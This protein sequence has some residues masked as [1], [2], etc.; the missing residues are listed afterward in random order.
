MFH[1][2]KLYFRLTFPR[3]SEEIAAGIKRDPE[4]L[5]LIFKFGFLATTNFLV[6][7]CVMY[8]WAWGLRFFA[9]FNL[10]EL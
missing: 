8:S 10:K 7:N 4:Y 5:I 1:S 6:I 9:S 3:C 2:A